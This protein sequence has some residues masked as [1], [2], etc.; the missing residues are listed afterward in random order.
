MG[1]RRLRL[2]GLWTRGRGRERGVRDA[3]GGVEAPH[4]L[5]SGAAQLWC[6]A[7][8]LSEILRSD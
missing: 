8:N 5:R 4:H 2:E 3:V 1:R 7:L 6:V